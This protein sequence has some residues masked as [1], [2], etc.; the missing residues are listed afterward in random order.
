M[1][2]RYMS[3]N[4]NNNFTTHALLQNVLIWPQ[5]E[6]KIYLQAAKYILPKSDI[7]LLPEIE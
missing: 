6:C 7:L 5:F 1:Q 3:L 2:I 4:V